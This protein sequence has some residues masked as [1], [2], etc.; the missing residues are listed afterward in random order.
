M[1]STA[2]TGH[3]HLDATLFGRLGPFKHGVGRAV[4]GNDPDLVRHA[5]RFKH[6]DAV[7]HGFP[8]SLRTHDDADQ[9]RTAHVCASAG[10]TGYF[11]MCTVILQSAK[12]LQ[13]TS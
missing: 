11:S 4:R 8:I 3:H 1:R 6:L 13:L 9:W 10:K 2:G 12:A 7:G 5:K